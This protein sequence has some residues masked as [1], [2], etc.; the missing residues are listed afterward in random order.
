M[1]ERINQIISNLRH[2]ARRLAVCTRRKGGRLAGQADPAEAPPFPHQR[3]EEWAELPR[4]GR[5]APGG[6]P[7]A[8]RRPV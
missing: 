4:P 2:A 3:P 8:G 1:S 5:Q 7:P 6:G